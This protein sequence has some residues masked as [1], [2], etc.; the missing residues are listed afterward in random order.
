MKIRSVPDSEVVIYTVNCA[1]KNYR[2]SRDLVHCSYNVLQRSR[3]TL[4]IT[5][6]NNES[7]AREVSLSIGSQ[8]YPA[9]ETNSNYI[10]NSSTIGA[11]VLEE[12]IWAPQGSHD[13]PLRGPRTRS[14]CSTIS[15][16]GWCGI[17]FHLGFT[18]SPFLLFTCHLKGFLLFS[19]TLSP[20]L[21]RL[22]ELW[23][24]WMESLSRRSS[25]CS[26]HWSDSLA[27]SFMTHVTGEAIPTTAG[28]AVRMR[29]GQIQYI[30]YKT[31]DW[32]NIRWIQEI[33]ILSVAGS[34]NRRVLGRR[35]KVHS[36]RTRI[37]SAKSQQGKTTQHAG[38]SNNT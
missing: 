25:S 36:R 17:F 38:F 32:D 1:A 16:G 4:V 7:S 6:E 14:L 11:R 35:S 34:P 24:E 30:K 19:K 12:T 21:E 37:Y 33:M 22:L 15:R 31:K 18:H 29:G 13:L 10:V 23:Q 20:S 8:P 28:G 26:W 27:E 3:N 2:D 5:P 9:G